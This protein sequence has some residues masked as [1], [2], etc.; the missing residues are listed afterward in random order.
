MQA[1][2]RIITSVDDY[3]SHVFLNLSQIIWS[4]PVGK[5]R[6]PTASK[7]ATPYMEK[8]HGHY[9]WPFTLTLP[10]EMT[11]SS[12]STEAFCLPQTFLERNMKV[13]VKYDIYVHIRRRKFRGNSQ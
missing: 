4:R 11:L 9:S 1:E 12:N 7:T 13:S 8:L 2:G 10:H 5:S 3:D 6:S